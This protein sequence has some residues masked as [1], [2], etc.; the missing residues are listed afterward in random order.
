MIPTYVKLNKISAEFV[1][2]LYNLPAG[3]I[4]GPYKPNTTV[5]LNQWQKKECESKS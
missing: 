1:D 5:F 2:A 4:Y 3:E